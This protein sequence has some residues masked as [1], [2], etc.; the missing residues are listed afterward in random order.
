MSYN[1]RSTSP[2]R[3]AINNY[4]RMSEINTGSIRDYDYAS[5]RSSADRI[6]PVSTQTF[7]RERAPDRLGD[8]LYETTHTRPRR[9]TFNEAPRPASVIVNSAPRPSKPIIS[10]A[11]PASPLAPSKHDSHAKGV[12]KMYAVDEN[13]TRLV[14][15]EGSKR[16][17]NRQTSIDRSGHHRRTSTDR[18]GYIT[19]GGSRGGKEY[20]LTGPVSR[21]YIEPTAM[22]TQTEPV[23]RRRKGSVDGARERPQSMLIESSSPRHSQR[24]LGPPPSRG[25]DRYNE[26]I[27]R[28]NSTRHSHKPSGHRTTYEDSGYTS[29][30]D[31]ADKSRYPRRGNTIPGPIS[32]IDPYA[33]HMRAPTR[34]V[35]AIHDSYVVPPPVIMPAGQYASPTIATYADRYVQDPY[36]DRREPRTYERN[37]PQRFKDPSVERRGFGIRPA[38]IDRQG[39][40]ASN[41]S[42]EK[43]PAF[44]DRLPPVTSDLRDYPRPRD[45]DTSRA[46]VPDTRGY[47]PPDPERER[48]RDEHR[49]DGRRREKESRRDTKDDH[50]DRAKEVRRHREHERDWDYDR[51]H[52]KAHDRDY[53]RER[54]KDRDREKR[55][56]SRYGDDPYESKI[57]SKLGGMLPAA[58]AGAAAMYGTGEVLNKKAEKEKQ[59]DAVPSD[60]DRE[61]RRRRD[62][63]LRAQDPGNVYPEDTY[64]REPRPVETSAAPPPPVAAAAAAATAAALDPDEEYRRRL[65]Q[66]QQETSR[67]R[68]DPYSQYAAPP[69][70]AP[71]RDRDARD[72]DDHY[73]EQDVHSSRDLRRPG[74]DE[75]TRVSDRQ[76][77]SNGRSDQLQSSGSSEG[78]N[79]LGEKKPR[80]RIVEPPSENDNR[81]KGIL[82]KPKSA[83]PEDPNP[84]REGVA[85]LK[86]KNIP[87]NI[88]EN[89]RWTKVKRSFV[90]PEALDL[91]KER[92]E[93]RKDHVIILRVVTE[94]ELNKLAELTAEIRRTRERRERRERDRD[95]DRHE[96]RES[97]HKARRDADEYSDSDSEDDEFGAKR[98]APRMLEGPAQAAP[99]ATF[100]GPQGQGVAM[101]APGQPQLPVGYAQEEYGR[102]RREKERDGRDRERERDRGD[103]E[104]ERDRDRDRD[105]ERERERERDRDRDRDRD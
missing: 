41:E 53:D 63:D 46:D 85:P 26:G 14:D 103:R 60:E 27:M 76:S 45:H 99:P 105:R 28:S 55:H 35:P 39:A 2:G 82:K 93:E 21:E 70:E 56:D 64:R 3:R 100:S 16:G 10:S 43:R 48:M 101:Q 11:R 50:D 12:K 36:E 67:A 96:D 6:I 47:Y 4:G 1:Y 77:Y 13:K 75:A 51:E 57:D 74:S 81:P 62:D 7:L 104:R 90:N 31:Y 71:R 65:Q 78:M 8:R 38:S 5:P 102:E 83:F 9:S 89:A 59:V 34:S 20:H 25:L 87:R 84:I 69:Q 30:D 37:Q 54:E 58:M 29:Q 68:P 79:E 88:P 95:R 94:E 61:R 40:R 17:H 97:R 22:F 42:F 86:D 15:V 49:D 44:E 33:D 80:V 72:R 91:A 73:S 23:R 32:T 18:T 52:D 92:Y 98:R 66:A 19:T 24:D